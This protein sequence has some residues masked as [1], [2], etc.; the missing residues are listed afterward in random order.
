MSVLQPYIDRG[1]IK[2]IADGYTKEWLP[3][4]AYL[5]MLKALDSA[6][7]HITAVLASNDGMAGGAIQ[8]LREHNLAGKVLVTGQDADLTALIFIVQG[9]QAMT[10]YKPVKNEAVRAAEEAVRLAKK[11][12][13]LAEWGNKQ[14]TTKVPTVMLTPVVVTKDNI[15]TTVVQDGFQKL[16]SINQA[17]SPE[18]QIK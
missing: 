6:Q 10:I 3:T 17:L 16:T 5:F 14:R 15:K 13:V 1:D 9:T 7:D 18:E 8:A 11:E 12:K 2:V 4:E